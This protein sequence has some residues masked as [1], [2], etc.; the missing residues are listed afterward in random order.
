MFVLYLDAAVDRR[1]RDAQASFHAAVEAARMGA[2][3]SHDQRQYSKWANRPQ[4]PT[5]AKSLTGA[6]LEAAV[7]GIARLFPGNVLRG[8]V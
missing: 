6:A 7:M 5:K 1:T 2:I 8:T 4:S 3:F